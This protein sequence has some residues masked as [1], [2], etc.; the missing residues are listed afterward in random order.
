MLLFVSTNY[1]SWNNMTQLTQT[2]SNHQ[3]TRLIQQALNTL[4]HQT[5]QLFHEQSRWT[6]P[7]DASNRLS[8]NWL[9]LKIA[10]EC[11]MMILTTLCSSNP[12]EIC[13]FLQ[14]NQE[15]GVL[16]MPLFT[17]NTNNTEA[18][19]SSPDT[20][21]PRLFQKKIAM[22]HRVRVMYCN[23]ALISFKWH[24]DTVD[25]PP[26]KLTFY[27][28]SD[29]LVHNIHQFMNK[30]GL[31]C[32]TVDFIVTPEENLIFMTVTEQRDLSWIK[33]GDLSLNILKR[34]IRFLATCNDDHTFG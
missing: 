5:A 23:K 32:A 18:S 14:E 4:N 7:S 27:R 16:E 2:H 19:I 9:Q 8:F 13:L 26:T 31:V 24:A 6:N 15:K 3:H 33:T 20:H 17:K 21:L 10:S 1:S 22:T 34:L 25:T 29:E 30:I 11:G 28:I 12:N